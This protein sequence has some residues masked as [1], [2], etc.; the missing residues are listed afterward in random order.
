MQSDSNAS[1]F[2]PLFTDGRPLLTVGSLALSLAGIFAIFLAAAGQFLPHDI[3][4][5]GMTATDLCQH[6]ACK[7]VHFMFHDRVSFGGVLVSL[8]ILYL[9]LIHFPLR[10]GQ[11]W[12]WWTLF[13]S[14]LAGFASFLSYLSFGYLD[15]WHAAAT[16][17]LLPCFAIGLFL[18]YRTLPKPHSIG[19]LL[20]P[21]IPLNIRTILQDGT[22][23]LPKRL[24]R[25]LLLA[26]SFALFFAG[27]TITLVGMTIV[28]VP[29]DL[30][31]M[32]TTIPT[33]NALNP[34]LI[35]LI[36]H[37]RAGFGAGLL[38][39]GFVLLAATWCATPSRHQWQA[40]ILAG[41]IGFS[42]AIGVHPI[43]GYNNPVHLAPAIMGALCF[44]LALALTHPIRSTQTLS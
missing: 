9:W 42:C 17:A 39:I 19:C 16:L 33:L 34:R 43:V 41:V 15:T 36:A 12:A 13:L 8:S 40:F 7:I 37:D 2:A 18:S 22:L 14:T 6:N 44:F 25:P 24:G 38:N 35:P 31:Y 28:F 10:S 1:L 30:S 27:L 26:I 3:Q 4:F 29:E 23:P 11:P 20:K 5:L 21:S 32:E